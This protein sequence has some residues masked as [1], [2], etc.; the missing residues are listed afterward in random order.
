MELNIA[1]PGGT[2]G[3]VSVSEAAFGKEFNPELVHQAITAY[4]A[5]ERQGTKAEKNRP[6]V[7]GG[8]R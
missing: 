1:T 8:G 4:T 5:G 6:A 2:N 3:T 7:S